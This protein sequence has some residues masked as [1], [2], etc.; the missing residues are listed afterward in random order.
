MKIAWT[1]FKLQSG[2]DFV[3]EFKGNNSKGIN[4]RVVVLALCTSC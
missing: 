1:I 4:A 3:T 2:H